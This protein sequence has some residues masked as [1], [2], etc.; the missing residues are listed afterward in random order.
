MIPKPNDSFEA[1]HLSIR[2]FSE[3]L[4]YKKLCFP[5]KI[6]LANVNKVT[7]DLLILRIQIF[8][9]KFFNILYG[10]TYLPIA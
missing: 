6:F 1:S 3:I 4:L 10:A 8:R 5:L 7:V 2:L 9:K